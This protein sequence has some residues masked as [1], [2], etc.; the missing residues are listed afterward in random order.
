MVRIAALMLAYLFLALA[1]VGV[2]VPGLPTVPFLLLAAASASKG[3]ERLHSWLYT[4][5]RF[6]KM[7]TDWDANRAIS[8]TSKLTAVAMLMVS[9]VIMYFALVDQRVLLGVGVLFIVVA[10]YLLSRPDPE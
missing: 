2:F 4:H 7:L 6:G 1:V 5:P 3:S 8:R 10:A 9:F